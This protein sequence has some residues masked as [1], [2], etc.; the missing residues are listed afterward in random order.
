MTDTFDTRANQTMAR[1][2]KARRLLKAYNA[3]D[4]EERDTRT[5]ILSDLLGTCRPGAWI[6][7][8]FFCDYGDNIHLGAG[9]FINFNCTMLDCARAL[10]DE[11]GRSDWSGLLF[12][13]TG[14]A[15]GGVA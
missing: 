3:S 11:K 1:H 10:S 12:G 6:E 7:P 2:T 4:A 5:Q 13:L 15:F 14:V 9:V 8:P